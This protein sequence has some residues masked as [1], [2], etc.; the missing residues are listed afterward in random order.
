LAGVDEDTI[1]GMACELFDDPA[2]Y[3]K[4]AHAV[5]PYGDGRT[6]ARIVH[7]IERYFGLREDPA[8]PFGV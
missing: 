3:E 4:M 2:A 5:N 8:E 1:F 7:E 6:S